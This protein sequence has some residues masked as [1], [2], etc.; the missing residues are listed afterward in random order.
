MMRQVDPFADEEYP[1]DIFQHD[2]EVHEAWTA[3]RECEDNNS[4]F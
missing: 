4:S 2:I 1:P 3:S